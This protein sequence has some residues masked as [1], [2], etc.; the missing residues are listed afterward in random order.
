MESQDC[1]V[2]RLSHGT[3]FDLLPMDGQPSK[4]L[5]RL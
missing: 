1:P 2:Q 3:V 5:L 4:Q